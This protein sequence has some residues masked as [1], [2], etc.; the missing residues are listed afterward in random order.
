ML[1]GS[2]LDP[3]PSI[4]AAGFGHV[5]S[6]LTKSNRA[7]SPSQAQHAVPSSIFA[8]DMHDESRHI[9]IQGNMGVASGVQLPSS[10]PAAPLSE[11]LFF[12]VMLT[13]AL[14]IWKNTIGNKQYKNGS[15]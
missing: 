8:V 13:W 1:T 12:A 3:N 15:L 6:P 14:S 9:V 2:D 5:I 10:F 4:F 11:S 7:D